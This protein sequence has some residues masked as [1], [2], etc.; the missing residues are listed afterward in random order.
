MRLSALAEDEFLAGIRAINEKPGGSV[1]VFI[2]GY[3]NEFEDAVGRTAQM[4]YDL[5]FPGVPVTYIWPTRKAWSPINYTTSEATVQWTKPHL[6]EFLKTLAQRT[7]AKKIH[8]IAHSMG[9]RVLADA[10]EEVAAECGGGLFDQ[11]ILAAPD[12]DSGVFE[13]DIAPRLSAS[14]GRVTLYASSGD[15]ALKLSKKAPGYPRAGE[16]GEYLVVTRS[17]DT[18]DVS[19][20]DLDLLGS[21]HGYFSVCRDI[22]NDIYA[23]FR[24]GL[25]PR[26][27]ICSAHIAV[28]W[29]TGSLRVKPP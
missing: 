17:V 23:L 14:C 15:S 9:S 24:H 21:A 27:A 20:V 8:L 26:T 12:I 25:S 11:V 6:K 16:G 7:G 4:A 13:R 1:F 19:E 22:I 2:H 10:V 18:I 3:N 28:T 29:F 5:N